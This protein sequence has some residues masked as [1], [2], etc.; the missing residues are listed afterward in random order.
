[1]P[2]SSLSWVTC[3]PLVLAAHCRA[4]GWATFSTGHCSLQVP[5]QHPH[6][7]QQLETPKTLFQK[8]AETKHTPG[9]STRLVPPQA[10]SEPSR[11]IISGPGD[12]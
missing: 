11:E 2:Q 4:R 6:P 12:T 5:S 1:M 9:S 7:L 10:L 8:W 3:V